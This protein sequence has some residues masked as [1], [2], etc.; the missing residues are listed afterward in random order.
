MG[1]QVLA[2]ILCVFV[3]IHCT[4]SLQVSPP[5]GQTIPLGNQWF[6]VSSVPANTALVQYSISSKLVGRII[7]D[8]V[9]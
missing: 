5:T 6:E 7:A 2:K 9:C 3:F 1:P 4:F 8:T